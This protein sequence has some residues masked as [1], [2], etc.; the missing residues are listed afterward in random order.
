MAI[1]NRRLSPQAM[2]TL[3][4]LAQD[5]GV[6]R[7]GLEIAAMTGLASGTLYP[8]LAR[9][10]E[11]GLVEG[12]WLDPERPGRPPRHGYRIT[13]AGQAAIAQT[14]VNATHGLQGSL[15]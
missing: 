2:A 7:Y 1:R 14:P 11:R 8:I 12:C 9:L 6:W 5:P 10:D 4:A 13:A 3:E 15:A